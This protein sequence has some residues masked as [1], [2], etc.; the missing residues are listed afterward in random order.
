MEMAE[1]DYSRIGNL[2]SRTE[3][4]NN[5]FSPFYMSFGKSTACTGIRMDWVYVSEYHH[6]DEPS[7]GSFGTEEPRLPI[8]EPEVTTN[9]ATGVEETNATIHGYLSG[10][11][12]ESCTVWFEYGA[13]TG[14]GN[15]TNNQTKTIFE[16]FTENISSLSQGTL[17]HYRAVANNSNSTDYGSDKA[18]LTKPLAPVSITVSIHNLTALNLTWVKGTGANNT[19]IERNA[20][21]VTNWSRGEGTE[22]YNGTGT[23]Y[24]DSDLLFNVEYYYQVW[25]YSEWSYNPTLYQYSDDNASDSETPYYWSPNVTTNDATGVEETNATLNGYLNSTGGNVTFEFYT[26]EGNAQSDFSGNNW[27]AQTFT[28]GTNGYNVTFNATSI[29]LNL[30]GSAS[31]NESITVGIRAVNAT[32]APTGSDLANATLDIPSYGTNFYWTILNFTTPCQLTKGETYAIVL[33][34]SNGTSSNYIY[35]WAD[36]YNGGIIWSSGNAGATWNS[37]S[38]DILFEVYSYPTTWFVYGSTTNYGNTTNNQTKNTVDDINANI[39]G[40]PEGTLHHYQVV[41]KNDAG[42]S[43]GS[44]KAFLTKP[45]IPI[46]LTVTQ[47]NT[48]QINLTWTKGTGANNTIIERNATGQTAWTRGSGTEIYN[49]SATNYEDTALHFGT[50]YYYQAWSHTEWTYNPTLNQY[51]DENSSDNTNLSYI[52]PYNLN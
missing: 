19:V 30:S 11:G 21:A 49:G 50:T 29:G 10:H 47:Y 25:S 28:V 35:N 7:W 36:P 12:G 39:T 42:T 16:N 15:T 9:D 6:N 46:S 37:A 32:N 4:F 8:T 43:Y 24:I 18:F 38:G 23:T 45:L 31:N 34:L 3:E 52:A 14:Y 22:I 26:D 33:R 1:Y 5:S 51:S 48:T 44:D 27:V 13:S 41:A 20:T 2:I 40:L 17:Y